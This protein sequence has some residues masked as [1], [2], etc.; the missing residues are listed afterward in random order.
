MIGLDIWLEQATQCLSE[1]SA[2]RVRSEIREHYES[3][4]DTAIHEGAPIEEAGRWALQALGDSKTANSQYR[5]VLLTAAEA[6]LLREGNREAGAVC[7]RPWLKWV[8]AAVPPAAVATLFFTGH[9]AVA[10]DVL[11]AGLGVS[12]MLAAPFLSLSTPGRGR[13]FRRVKWVAIT[14][15]LLLVYGADSLRWSWLL[16]ACLWPLAWTEWTRASI[17]R[18]L[19]VAAWPKQLYL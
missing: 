19:P 10:R 1:E 3:A 13:V 18:K 15:G 2:A 12:P 17:R 6:R 8:A 16:F 11:I 9:A 7:S 14:S 5:R 4:R